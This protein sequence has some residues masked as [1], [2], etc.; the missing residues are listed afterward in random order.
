[1]EAIEL[2]EAMKTIDSCLS[3]M[4]WS[5]K[6]SS[7]RRLQL[8]II[9]LITRMRPVVMI[10]YGGIMP[11][12]QHQLSSL[13]QLA[14]NQS[15]IFQQLRLMV[16]QEMIYF[17]HVTELTHFVNSSLDSK[18]LF[19]DL[20][21][22]SPQLITE[23]EKSQLA[24]QMVSIQKLF[25]TVFSSNGEEKLK[26]DANSSAH[27]SHCS[28][29]EC[30]DLS[31]CMENTDI[32]VPTLN[33]WLLGYPVVY[34]F[35]K[36][37]ISDAVY[38]LSTKYLHIFQVFVCRNSN[39]NKGSQTEELLSFSVPYDLSTRGSKEQWAEAFLAHMQAKWERC[40]KVW[41]SLKMEVSECH[42]Q[43]IVL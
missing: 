20:E 13:L 29:T 14:Q 40:P 17:I 21:H 7:K 1:M 43:A 4:N 30:I 31:Y 10:D 11:Q 18:L 42:P 16:I 22:E 33:G 32:L 6:S 12:L 23:I 41:K 34:L 8:D 15:Q 38:N 3:Q 5:L 26:D 37:H 9:A 19:V 36:D 39:L 28:S 25:S 35:G 2:D 24:M 27:C